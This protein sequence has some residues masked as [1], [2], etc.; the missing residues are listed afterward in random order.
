MVGNT[1]E[2]HILS[3]ISI[4]GSLKSQNFRTIRSKTDMNKSCED[5]K[6]NWS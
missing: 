1:Q 2:K 6:T 5:L 4:G 3:S